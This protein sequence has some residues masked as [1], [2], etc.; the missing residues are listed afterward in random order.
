MDA[1][2]YFRVSMRPMDG[3]LKSGKIEF[4]PMRTR[5]MQEGIF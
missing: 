4:L 2:N 3:L 1:L 5:K